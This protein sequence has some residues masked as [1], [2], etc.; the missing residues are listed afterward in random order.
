M[1]K[2]KM[3]PLEKISFQFDIVTNIL[4]R[5]KLVQDL[6]EMNVL[7]NF[8]EDRVENVA[9]RV[10]TRQMVKPEDGQTPDKM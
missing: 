2:L 3:W 4:T 7:I 9:C 1:L 8:H 5:F 10:L 6:M